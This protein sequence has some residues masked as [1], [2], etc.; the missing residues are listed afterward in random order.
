[1]L[2]DYIYSDQITIVQW[3]KIFS[4]FLF[5]RKDISRIPFTHFSMSAITS[6]IPQPN[7]L[8]HV[9]M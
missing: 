1:M 5:N 3:A 2:L 8:F 7:A 6:N 9:L 4:L